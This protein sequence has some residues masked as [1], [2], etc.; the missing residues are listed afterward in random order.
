MYVCVRQWCL[1]SR[2]VLQ[3]KHESDG[4]NKRLMEKK[5]TSIHTMCHSDAIAHAH[6]PTHTQ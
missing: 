3:G 4:Q 5:R 1:N 6:T 2:S